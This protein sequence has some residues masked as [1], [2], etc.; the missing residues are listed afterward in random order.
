MK[1]FSKLIAMALS[2][3]MILALATAC[4]GGTNPTP[5]P[6][7]ANPTPNGGDGGNENTL[8]AQVQAIKDRG[9]L[10]VGVKSDVPGFGMQDILTGE[11]SGIEVDLARKI[12]ESMGLSADNVQFT[13]VT[14]KTRGQLLDSGDIDLVL[15]T[16]TINEER[17]Q[18]WN[19][20]SPYYTDAVSLLV[21]QDTE[22]ATYEDLLDKVVGVGESATSNDALMAAA[23]ENGVTLTESNFK[24]FPDYPSIKAA[25]DAGQV[26]VFCMDA[27]TLSGYLDDST[28]IVSG[29]SFAPQEYGV[30]SKLD[31]KELAAY[32]ENL[33]ST[34]LSD[35]TID[36]IIA[37]NGVA[38]SF[39]G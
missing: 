37:D 24:T 21:K 38:A 36:Q 8:P 2:V 22:L 35:G 3:V 28:K 25:L 4:G 34:W 14:A 18:T 19:F 6:T 31:N 10:R 39:E 26:D 27:S 1:K 7:P 9:V 12:A 20:S 17:K 33:I 15:A 30:A 5:T 23:A 13:T 11:Y 32:V 16:F 29:L